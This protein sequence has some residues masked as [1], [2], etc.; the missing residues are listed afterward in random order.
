MASYMVAAKGLEG[1]VVDTSDICLIDGNAGRLIYRG[2]DIHDLVANLSFEEVAY[3]LWNGKLPNQSQLDEL[4]KRLAEERSIPGYLKNAIRNLPTS[5]D[6]LDVLRTAVSTVGTGVPLARPNL[7]QAIAITAKIPTINAAFDRTR[8]GQEP[9]D[10]NPSLGHTANYLYMLTGKT[11]DSTRA[12]ALDKYFIALADH[13]MNSSTFAARVVASTWSDMY[14]AIV[15]AIGALKGPLHGGAP[16]PVLKM[17]QD[18]TKPERAEE[19]IRGELKAGR[20]LMG[21]GHRVYRTTDPR[22]EILRDVA[23]ETSDKDFFEL[24]RRVEEAGNRILRDYRP[25]R[26][27]YTNVEFYSAVVMNS[28]GLPPDLFTPTFAASRCVGWTANV[29]EQTANNRLIRP[30]VEYTGPKDLKVIP[31]NQR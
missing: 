19:W 23:S 26:R 9:I 25:G 13:S 11:P 2:Y 21:F 17:L 15:A 12:K 24:A 29:L 28:V 3:L 22:A 18:I 8:R 27:L 14:S 31:I 10:P 30:E 6:H 4:K 7:T 1:V 20:R 16:A 5:S